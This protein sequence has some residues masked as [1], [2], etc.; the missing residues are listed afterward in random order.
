MQGEG[1]SGAIFSGDLIFGNNFL[2]ARMYFPG[3]FLHRGYFPF[4]GG[5]G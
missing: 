5:G 3:K 1:W 4:F 2:S